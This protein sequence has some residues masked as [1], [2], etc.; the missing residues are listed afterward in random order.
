MLKVLWQVKRPPEL[1]VSLSSYDSVI[2]RS[3]QTLLHLPSSDLLPSAHPQGQGP[4]SFVLR[5]SLPIPEPASSPAPAH[6]HMAASIVF[7]G[8][9]AHHYILPSLKVLC[10]SAFIVFRTMNWHSV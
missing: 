2:T 6:S 3:W 8:G 10:V 4:A 9:Q 7:V 5:L 1:E